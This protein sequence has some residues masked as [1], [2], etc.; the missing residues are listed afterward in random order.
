MLL[1]PALPI[2]DARAEVHS[3]VLRYVRTFGLAGRAAK[4]KLAL[5]VSDG[6]WNALVDGVE[7][8]RATSG[9]GDTRIALEV[10]FAGAP[11]LDPREFAAYRL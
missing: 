4:L 7:R 3:G 10:N 9:L 2:E 8:E 6:T 1:D 5:P 11:A